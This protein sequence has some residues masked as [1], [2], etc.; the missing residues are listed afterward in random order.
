MKN[1]DMIEYKENFIF[2]IK[3]FF[4]NLFKKSKKQTVND[5]Q[6]DA[7]N[8]NIF[9]FNRVENDFF[10][11]IKVEPSNINR[12]VT[13]KKFLEYIDGNVE[14]LKMLSV[15]RLRKLKAYYDEVIKENNKIIEKL[16]KD[17]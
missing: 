17:T 16:K 15:D 11:N 7:S 3:G 5:F 14:A 4:S 8:E 2:K 6:L 10:D 12:V 1:N 13:S 9:D